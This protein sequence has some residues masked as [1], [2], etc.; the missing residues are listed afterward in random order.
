MF[1]S[2]PILIAAALAAAPAGAAGIDDLVAE[3]QARAGVT[4]DPAA[5]EKLWYADF[6]GRSC[7]S[8][9]GIDLTAP[10]RHEKTGKPIDPIA[11]SANPDR[12]TDAATVEKW[13]KRNCQWTLGRE[14]S[15][16]EKGNLVS[17][18]RTR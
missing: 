14:C 12:L 5:G 8:C 2:Y 18:L 13:L 16:L 17:W 6:D 11:P 4:F 10:G 7:G 15:D 1:N 9:H 3:W